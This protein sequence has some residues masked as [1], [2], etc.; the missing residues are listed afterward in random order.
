MRVGGWCSRSNLWR[1]RAECAPTTLVWCAALSAL[2]LVA[3]P[4]DAA[5][6]AA[7]ANLE[8]QISFAVIAFV[9]LIVGAA[10][11][12]SG[13]ARRRLT[14]W[15]LDMGRA[16]D[17]AR[18]ST[19]LR[20]YSAGGATLGLRPR[21][22]SSEPGSEAPLRA[23]RD[24]QA[25]ADRLAR[26]HNLQRRSTASNG[27]AVRRSDGRRS[28]EAQRAFTLNDALRARED[29]PAL[30]SGPATPLDDY[31]FE[32]GDLSPP[33]RL[34]PPPKALPPVDAGP[35]ATE[36]EELFQELL[37]QLRVIG[38]LHREQRI[39]RSL[40]PP[41]SK[42]TLPPKHGELDPEKDA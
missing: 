15:P 37:A 41:A 16:A 14:D 6:D 3:A 33:R 28:A 35:P 42:P 13:R 30:L 29:R 26:I 21:A 5:T 18:L 38:Q 27:E 39:K 25:L 2:P 17:G 9:A 19:P 40:T 32:L 1:R 20:G 22:F 31:L 4:A 12:A 10:I 34:G 24:R 7:T 23:A 8:K 36:R 11:A